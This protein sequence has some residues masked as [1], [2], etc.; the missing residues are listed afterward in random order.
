MAES[1][2]TPV[3][4]SSELLEWPKRDKGRFLHVVS[5]VGDLFA[6]SSFG[7]KLLRKRDIPEEKYTNA[8]LGF[9]PEESQ[10][11]VELT[12]N[13]LLSDILLA[14]NEPQQSNTSSPA[15]SS[16]RA[17]FRTSDRLNKYSSTPTTN[18]RS[19]RPSSIGSRFTKI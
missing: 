16:Q 6:L 14:E 13:T 8:F 10:F 9:G 12:Y 2:P 1:E 19:E 5:R 7:M 11:V 4:P 17:S 3:V 18:D 15:L